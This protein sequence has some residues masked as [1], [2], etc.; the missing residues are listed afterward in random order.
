MED[1]DVP[2]RESTALSADGTAIAY[3]VAGRGPRTLVLAPGL[4][5]HPVAWK[6][7]IEALHERYQLI[8]WAPRGTYGS[9]VPRD[10]AALTLPD[11]VRDLE[12]IAA[13]EGLERFLLAGWSMGV[14]IALEFAHQFPARVQALILING[15]FEHVLATAFHLPGAARLLPSVL[16]LGVRAAPVMVPFVRAVLSHPATPDLA[17]RL[18]LV[19][20]NVAFFRG[21]VRR[22]AALDW[23]VYFQLMLQLNEH[24]ARPYLG[25]IRVPTLITAGTRDR[26]TPVTT[27]EQ[28]HRAIPGSRLFLLPNGTHYA[29]TEYPEILQLGIDDFL[30]TVDPAAFAP[31]AGTEAPARYL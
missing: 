31:A 10:L 25:D 7:V 22:F 27:A 19:S 3:Y 11:H 1:I 18:G 8:T 16:R 13:A 24:S 12:A 23:N 4:G 6:Y 21:M 17:F 30:R 2:V 15:A 28:L 14:Q 9:G 29:M 20:G 26:M 5:T